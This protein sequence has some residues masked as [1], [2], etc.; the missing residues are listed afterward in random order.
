MIH[1]NTIDKLTS[2]VSRKLAIGDVL[3]TCWGYDQTNVDFYKVIELV[4]KASVK[5]IKIASEKIASGDMAGEII[6]SVDSEMGESFTKRTCRRSGSAVSINSHITASLL[7][8]KIIHGC[9]IYPSSYEA[10]SIL[11]LFSQKVS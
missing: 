4:G 5:I 6:P 8:P 2:S 11:R 10:W 1:F 3:K 7:V 9:K